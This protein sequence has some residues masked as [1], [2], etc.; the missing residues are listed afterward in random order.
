MNGP[1]VIWLMVPHEFVD[2][3]LKKL[4]PLLK[5]GDVVIDGGNS[6][7]KKGKER[8]A[9][10]KKKG[11]VFMD[12]GV[13]GGIVGARKGASRISAHAALAAGMA[14]TAFGTSPRAVWSGSCCRAQ[15]RG[16]GPQ[17]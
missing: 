14:E 3:V 4:V 9:T 2:K 11:I 13:S 7:F 15:R 10:L 5:K 1:R 16:I 6:H 17:I 12:V 8:A